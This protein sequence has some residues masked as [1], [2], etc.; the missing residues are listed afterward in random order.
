MN[1]KVAAVSLLCA[2]VM[3]ASSCAILPTSSSE[4]D[5]SIAEIVSTTV[6]EGTGAFALSEGQTKT[7]DINQDISGREY[8]KIT[9]ENNVNLLGEYKYSDVA[10]PGNVVTEPFYIEPST[11]EIEFKQFFDAFR[12]NAIGAFDKK[13]I[14]ITLKNLDDKIANINVKNITVTN[15]EVPAFEK[16]I[17]LEKGGLKVGA[18]LAMG[19]TLSYL[20][21]LD[22]NGQ[23]VDE[24]IDENDNVTIG[25][26]AKEGAKKYLSSSVNLINIY[27]A[28]REFQQSYYA[29]I[30]GNMQTATGANGYERR[31]S[32]TATQEGYYWPYNP[33]QGGDEVCNLSQIIDYEVSENAIYVKVRAMDWGN[34]YARAAHS[35]HERHEEF[36]NGRTTKSYIENTYT[37]KGGMLYVDN[38]FIDWNGFTDME[39]IPL[40]TLEIPA[41]YVVHP[42]SNYVCYVGG[43]AWNLSD[44]NYEREPDLPGWW[45]GDETHVNFTH[46]EDW[47]AWV[48]DEDF[49]VGVYVP[50]AGAY[51][52]GR[53]NPGRHISH[54]HN[55]DTANSKMANE[56]LYNKPAPTSDYTSCYVGNTSYTA[57]IV[58]VRMKEYIPI[59]YTYV[60]A[61]DYLPI[62]RSSFKNI[63]EA[64]VITNKG[65]EAWN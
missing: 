3:G 64:G 7:L 29:D 30:G 8:I 57:P 47:F 61:V 43:N 37:I 27:D 5:S 54:K 22:Y 24:V 18:D 34:G 53:N 40:H 10:N 48:N 19:G 45:L 9:L 35:T 38:R 26:N 23:T 21:K 11:E 13:L 25:V 60:V 33:V 46:P 16:E 49:G 55:S 12:P 31:W 59:S 56:Y 51:I 2:L 44:T 6:Y 15:R 63:H 41:A 17:Y 36:K 50:N 39:N 28:G 20:E 58:N 42:L 32:F 65:L 62:M 4:S 14:S 52:S 1:R